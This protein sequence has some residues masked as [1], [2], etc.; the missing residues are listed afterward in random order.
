MQIQ[1]ESS[2]RRHYLTGNTYAVRDRIR[3][4]GA[5]WDPA[6]RA[7]WTGK[8]EEA[9]QLVAALNAQQTAQAAQ[10]REQGVGLTDRVIRGRCEYKGKT[11]Y[12]LA[13]G[14]SRSGRPY[15]KLCS[16]DGSLVFWASAEHLPTLRVLKEYREP[17]SIEA[18]RDYAERAK[19][20]GGGRLEDGYYY[21][22]GGEVL[23]SGCSK[24][25]RLGQMCRSCQH[26][27][28]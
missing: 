4:M 23:A 13:H 24:C 11:Y 2:G 15:A 20:G 10:E 6:R 1:I 12:L 3:S 22:R 21:G 26:D 8:R 18:L 7:W 16:R 27:Y 9:E 5:H 19:Q 25:S 28:E 14:T 17:T